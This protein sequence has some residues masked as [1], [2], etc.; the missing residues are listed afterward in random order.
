[1]PFLELEW[2]NIMKKLF[3]LLTV[4]PLFFISC[5]KEESPVLTISQASISAQASGSSTTI[6][7]YANNP[8]AVS[9][10]DWCTVSPSGGE[11]GEV[12]VTITV[13]ENTTYDARNCTLTFSS[14]D[15]KETV[16]VN[17]DSNFG[18]V[19]P[20]NT[21][22][23]S[24]DAQ[25]ISVEV[26]AN[27]T[28]DVAVDADWIKQNGTKALTSKT[29]TFDIDKNESYD[30]REGTI[31]IKEKNGNDVKTI[32][33]KQA[34]VDAIIIS[35]K[36]YS[37]S[38]KAQS[39]E[40]K[41]Q[42]N[43]DLDV[44]IPDNAKPW[45]SHTSTKALSDK[46]LVFDIKENEDYSARSCEIIVKK[47]NGT[48]ADTVR[49][50]QV[51]KD[52]IVLSQK[53]YK[54]SSDKH[55]LEVKLQTNVDVEVNIPESA[56]SWISYIETKALADKVIILGIESNGTY[57]ERASEIYIKDKSSSLQDTI[58]IIQAQ[59]D[60]VI[61]S[62]KEYKLS[63]EKHSLEVKLQTNVDFE[64]NIPD[65]AKTWISF[66][67]TRAL[68]NKILVFDIKE[69][70]D[71]SARICEVMLNKGDTTFDKIRIEQ[72]AKTPVLL[73]YKTIDNSTITIDE[74]KFSATIISHT[75]ENG[76]GTIQ[77]D[78]EFEYFRS[79]AFSGNKKLTSITL[80]EGIKSIGVS[81]FENCSSLVRINLPGSV[82]EIDALAFS[83]CI[84]LTSINIPD[85]IKTIETW[86][87][88]N[89][90]SLENIKLPNGVI[91]IGSFAFEG[92]A[93]LVDINIPESVT[94]F[95]TGAFRGCSSLE[96]IEIPKDI[97]T[98]AGNVFSGC[99]SLKRVDIP[100]SVTIIDGSAF[101][102]CSALTSLNI[103]EA[104]DY[105]GIAAFDG[106]SSLKSV[107][108]PNGVTA[109]YDWTFNGCSSL[110]SLNIPDKV[111]SIGRYAFKG[112]SSLTYIVIPA[113]VTNIGTDAFMNCV[114]LK[115]VTSLAA[116]AP[117][118]GSL[119]FYK[120][121]DRSILKVPKGCKSA[122]EGSSW[123]EYFSAIEEM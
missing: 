2:L 23:L 21:Y 48:F 122:Y 3:L 67:E 71:Y 37:L 14:L 100:K 63:S 22:E 4:L 78:N 66:I 55:S 87:F 40:V 77:F 18:I 64:V 97:T 19:L 111:T 53:E 34:Q 5:S 45:I 84:S 52:A 38:N 106:C 104:V 114:E 27:V 119:V 107:N 9:G 99:S 51:Q 16:S 33:I 31:V 13:K 93:S 61:L 109:I 118:L 32:K 54:L 68:N 113:G 28:Y 39:L 120:I 35:S 110:A 74:T 12:L 117:T 101:S 121:N 8:W 76:K 73:T 72:E 94:Y 6:T 90:K 82:T 88:Q 89:C 92:C 59:N 7:L 50:K 15:L 95:D 83:N 57:G 70:E 42:T 123:K 58:T 10:T 46:T 62:Q 49:I 47:K 79:G 43:V 11:G 96:S 102:G 29:F 81:A 86:T 56:K 112:C 24:C 108:I 26:K 30:A 80:P 115:T 20:K 75:Y 98:I 65:N 69:N 85:N 116:T 17:Q 1:M 25:Q 41:L 103:P 105:I 60:A 36:E 44:V 91:T